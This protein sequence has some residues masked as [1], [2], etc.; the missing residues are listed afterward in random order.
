MTNLSHGGSVDPVRGPCRYELKFV[1]ATEAN[2]SAAR[3]G[4]QTGPEVFIMQ[5]DAD[6]NSRIFAE[7]NQLTAPGEAEWAVRALNAYS[8]KRKKR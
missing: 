2:T 7:I 3:F 6:G 4:Y 8:R 5:V 1:E